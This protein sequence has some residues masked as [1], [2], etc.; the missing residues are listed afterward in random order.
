ML[1]TDVE[2]GGVLLGSAAGLAALLL[3]FLLYLNKRRWWGG[4]GAAVDGG[5]CYQDPLSRRPS[6]PVSIH[7]Q[8]CAAPP[9][10][11]AHDKLRTGNHTHT[12][13]ANNPMVN[14]LTL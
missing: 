4:A 6:T 13:I 2:G 11:T 5:R 8:T 10:V 3:V 1:V 9:P 14:R 7:T 12:C